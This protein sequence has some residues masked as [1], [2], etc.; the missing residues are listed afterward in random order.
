MKSIP[1]DFNFRV[2]FEIFISLII[3]AIVL[4]FILAAGKMNTKWL[5]F[6][7]LFITTMSVIMMIP[8]REKLFLYASVFFLSIKLD[9]NLIYIKSFFIRPIN[10]PVISIFD[11]PFFFLIVSWIVRIATKK[12]SVKLYPEISIPFFAIWILAFCGI[13]QSTAAPVIST[14][15]LLIFFENG[16]V[17]LYVANNV[18]D[19]KMLKNI[20]IIFMAIIIIQFILTVAQYLTGSNLGLSVFGEKKGA[21]FVVKAG[22]AI[23]LRPGGTFGHAN[24]LAKFLCL[25]L[26]LIFG[27]IFMPSKFFKKI[28]LIMVF[29]LGISTDILT[30]SRSSWVAIAIALSIVT[31]FA[32]M[33]TI[34]NKLLSFIITIIFITIISISAITF[35][36]PVKQRLFEDD[37]GTS[38]VRVPL[39]IVAFNIIKHNPLLGVGFCDYTHKAVYYDISKEGIY[40]YNNFPHPVHNEF[41]LIAGEMGLFALFFLFILIYNNFTNLIRTIHMQSTPLI[42]YFSVGLLGGFTATFLVMQLQWTYMF[43]KH[44]YWFAFGL[45]CAANNMAEMK[46]SGSNP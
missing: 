40:A 34:K 5:A 33:F 25:I 30:G 17:F 10:G 12:D 37:Y 14:W 26:P 4:F 38:E 7:I 11:V 28:I 21:L 6:I 23:I 3:G 1:V 15:A 18:K 29:S 35:L 46:N 2:F 45:A 32:I 22:S 41:L 16:L 8:S 19:E 13:F 44:H 36:N 9:V 27:L 43:L 42:T 20:I 24:N 39:T 31:Y